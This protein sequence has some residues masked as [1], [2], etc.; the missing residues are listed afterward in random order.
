MAC[1]ELHTFPLKKKQV[2]ADLASLFWSE[3]AQ[4]IVK[5][6]KLSKDEAATIWYKGTYFLTLL[7]KHFDRSSC[8]T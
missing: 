2:T 6:I 8:F 4:S 1:E 5:A 3:Y 7:A